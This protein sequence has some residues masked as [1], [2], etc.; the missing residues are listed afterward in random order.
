MKPID[1]RNETWENLQGHMTLI[2]SAV[3]EAWRKH[4]PGTT[5]DIAEKAGID[6]LTFRPRTTEL[7]QLGFLTLWHDAGNSRRREGVYRARSY[8][9][10][11]THFMAEQRKALDPQLTLL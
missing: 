4:G 11:L 2:R 1:Y 10:A 7:F 6:I 5:R 3:Y 9:E 8:Q